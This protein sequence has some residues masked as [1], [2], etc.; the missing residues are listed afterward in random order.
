[1]STHTRLYDTWSEAMTVTQRL[2]AANIDEDDISVLSPQSEENDIKEGSEGA[3]TGTGVGAALG[4]GAGALAGIGL[5][6][7]P[8]LGPVV[9]SGWLVAT[10]AGLASGAVVGGVAGGI[11]DALTNTG[12]T[13]E[14]ARVYAEAIRRGGT[15]ITVRADDSQDEL[16]K[17][18]L[19]ESTSV[20]IL[21]RERLYRDEGWGTD[22]DP[23]VGP[24]PGGTPPPPRF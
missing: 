18:I 6:S 1:M 19:D 12:M 7:I 8:G 20:D 17:R 9:A 23:L 5:L 14:E 16:V 13:A 15:V 11:V 10:L 24:G 2:R 3:L 21:E 4:G 22:V